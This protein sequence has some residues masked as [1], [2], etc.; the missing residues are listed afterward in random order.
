MSYQIL[1]N[2][3]VEWESGVKNLYIDTNGSK[4]P[5]LTKKIFFDTYNDR[6][7]YISYR[8]TYNNFELKDNNT[9][10]KFGAHEWEQASFYEYNLLDN[11]LS[12]KLSYYDID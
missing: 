3:T 12:N 8:Y 6:Y 11:T 7:D 9:I 2:V 5:I 4:K 10:L 1:L